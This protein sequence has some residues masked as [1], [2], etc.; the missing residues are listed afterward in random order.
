[1]QTRT[2][3][4]KPIAYPRA[5]SPSRS[6]TRRGARRFLLRKRSKIR[7]RRPSVKRCGR[8]RVSPWDRAKAATPSATHFYIRGF[9]ARNDVF[10]DGVRDAGVSIRENFDDE[11]IEIMR[12]PAS[13]FAGRG[14]TGGALNIVTKEAQ[15][16]DFYHFGAAESSPASGCPIKAIAA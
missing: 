5:S 6:L 4:I 1:M 13:S 14:T 10:I 15:N 16:T 11:Q 8:Q 2:R 3:L 7:T 9:D 12:G